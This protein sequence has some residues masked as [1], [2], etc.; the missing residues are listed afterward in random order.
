MAS[1]ASSAGSTIAL[2]APAA[3]DGSHSALT[4]MRPPRRAGARSSPRE[5]SDA[6]RAVVLT[7]VYFCIV[8]LGIAHHEMW[9]DEW[10]AWMVARDSG[11]I[12][13]MLGHLRHEGH[14]PTWHLILYF[15][16]RLTRD[17][18][19]MQAT[20]LII[21]TAS[22][23]LLA[24]YSPLP[25]LHKVLLASSYF[26]A[27]EY[28][29]IA[30][31][32]ALTV[33]AL[34]AFCAL[35]PVRGRH[36]ILL[37]IT[38]LALAATSA[39]G[40]ILSLVAVGMLLVESV[41]GSDGTWFRRTP[42]ARLVAGALVWVVGI[43]AALLLIMP[44]AGFASAVSFDD[45]FSQWSIAS[46]MSSLARAYLP[47]PAFGESPLWNSHFIPGTVRAGLAVTAVMGMGM[48][49]VACLLF[50]EKPAVLFFYAVGSGAL[51]AF[52]HFVFSGWMRHDGHLFLVFVACLWLMSMPLR[53]WT[54]PR[55]LG[56]WAGLDTAVA[57]I[58]VPAV[59]MVQVGAAVIF[60][61][62]E[63][64]GHFTAAPHVAEYIRQ[65]ELEGLPIAASPAPAASSVS[66]NLGRPIHYL[67]LG[68]EDT[69]VR[70]GEYPR[71]QDRQ[72]SLKRL[73]PFV[74]A[75]GTDVLLIMGRPVQEWDGG[76]VVDELS[77]FPAGLES[78]EG[79][80]IYRVRR[81][82]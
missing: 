63:L 74:E 73:G 20:H 4:R 53:E 49:I 81:A 64:R 10:Q 8:G 54:A 14:P 68:S 58:F 38:L 5:W 34:F 76:L 77:R 61:A 30:R 60:Y 44:P 39:F 59:L 82:P 36:P 65:Q 62:A 79:F 42:H 72:L 7:A 47:L 75:A 12:L 29:V 69:F 32:Y 71:G 50:V 70:W 1:V 3:E 15:L 48:G 24:R 56:R 13:E 40:L 26:L 6:R 25:W 37:F 17:P 55:R 28:A 21:A 67:A 23:Y 9:R 22:I 41:A 31:P 78:K 57:R 80:V 19:V 46:T 18:L 66:G 11:S 52:R 35:F 43:I 16:S 2:P 27:Y 45:A 33:L 51:L